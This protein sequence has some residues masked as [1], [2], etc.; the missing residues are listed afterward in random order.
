LISISLLI[1]DLSAQQVI[2]SLNQIER[3]A[4]NHYIERLLGEWALIMGEEKKYSDPDFAVIFK[5]ARQSLIYL[6]RKKLGPIR[7]YCLVESQKTRE[8]R[9]IS[10]YSYF[11]NGTN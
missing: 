4:L 10:R 1:R 6:K 9:S 7:K 11:Q 5:R 2:R 3:D 8:I